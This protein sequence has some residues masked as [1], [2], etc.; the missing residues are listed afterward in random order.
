MNINLVYWMLYFFIFVEI[1]CFFFFYNWL[2]WEWDVI[3]KD[4][5]CIDNIIEFLVRISWL[6]FMVLSEN[7]VKCGILEDI[8]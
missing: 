3:W 4:W 5:N 1:E 6:V 2:L 7:K 8:V